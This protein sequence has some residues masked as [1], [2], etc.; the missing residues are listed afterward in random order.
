MYQQT[1]KETFG[2]DSL[3]GGQQQVIEKV[4]NGHSSA[5]I[6]PT[7][8]GKSLCYQLP[9]LILPNLTLVISPLLAL[10]KDQIAFLKSKGIAAASI[11]STQTREETQAILQGVRNGEIKILMISVERLKNERFR[12]F[13]AQINISLLVVDEAHCISEWGHNFR[14]DYLK[15]PQDREALNIPQVLLLTATATPAV[16]EDM[17]KKFNIAQDDIV[18]TGFY[19][20]NLDISIIPVEEEQKRSALFATLKQRPDQPSIVYVTLQQTAENVAQWLQSN[21]IQAKAYHAGLKNDVREAIQH[22]FM[23]GEINCIVATIAFGMG[24]DKSDIRQVI[25]FD[26]P[27]SIE[28]YSQEIGRAGRDGLPSFCT[29]LANTSG[30]NVLEN[31]VYGDTPDKEAIQYVLD[32]IYQANETWETQLLRLSKDSNVRQLPLKTLLVYLELKKIIQAKYSYYA[33][34]RFKTLIPVND[35]IAKFQTERQQFVSTIFQCS[36]KAKT[37]HTVDFDA[38]WMGFRGERKRVIA[39]LDYFNEQGWI[40]LESKQMTEVYQVL[41]KVESTHV[42]SQEQHQLFKN[43]EQSEINRIHAMLDFFETKSCLSHALAHY[44]ADFN[45]PEKCGHCSACRS[46]AAVLPRSSSH[47]I[48]DDENVKAWCQE[49]QNSSKE[50]LANAVF[51]RFLCGIPTPLTSK[52]RANKM[53]G[54]GKFESQPFFEVLELVGKLNG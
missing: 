34:Y 19:R 16:I 23:H 28:N 38:L 52:I 1:L 6:F 22:Q 44:F 13:I 11:D 32:D 41:N 35:I 46:E 43:K 2:F 51:A 48:S 29:V 20:P 15:L 30:L 47:F 7:G 5:A 31:F 14:P 3:R 27:K 39:A 53:Q 37:W 54:F 42:L 24:V 45:A 9:A 26:L 36:P 10:M 49:L 18:I 8:S 50:P 17:S 25:H 4:L 21:G 12:Q 33:D 40:E